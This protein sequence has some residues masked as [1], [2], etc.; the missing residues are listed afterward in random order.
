MIGQLRTEGGRP[1][2]VAFVASF[3]VMFGVSTAIAVNPW[4]GNAND[5]YFGGTDDVDIAN[6]HGGKDHVYGAT[7]QDVLHGNDGWDIMS[8]QGGWDD[9]YGDDGND[10]LS[11]GAGKDEIHGAAD[12]DDI[13]GSS[14]DSGP[15]KLEGGEGSDYLDARNGIKD[16]EIDGGPGNDTCK[17]DHGEEGAMSSCNSFSY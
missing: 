5:N 8:G 17:I 6:G 9:T 16:D 1:V 11:T 2:V 13:T 15:N 12:D 10:D 7:N 4:D 14:P 3:V